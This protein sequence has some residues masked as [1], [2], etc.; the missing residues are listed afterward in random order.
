MLLNWPRY[1]CLNQATIA[2]NRC[3]TLANIV[4]SSYVQLDAAQWASN[5]WSDEII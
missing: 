3:H 4:C 1:I 2:K 5:Y